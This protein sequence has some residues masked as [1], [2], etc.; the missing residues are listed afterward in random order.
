MRKLCLTL[1]ACILFVGVYA[2]VGVTQKLLPIDDS[3][4][5][6]VLDNRMTYYIK[7]NSKPEKSA[8]FFIVHNVGAINESDNQD[9]LAH[10]LEHM[11]FNGTQNFPKKELVDYM[12][13][14]GATFGPNLNAFTG[15]E[16][17][18]YLMTDIPLKREAV[19]DSALLILNDWS[20]YISLV[21][22]E[23]DKERG[24]ILEELRTGLGADRRVF[25]KM[26][27]YLFN[28]TKYKDRLVI[29]TEEGLK[30]FKQEDIV[31]FY[32]DWYHP[33]NQAVVIIGD[34][35][36]AEV[37]TKV[38]KLFSQIPA[39]P[40]QPEKEKIVIPD[41]NED[42][43]AVITD[44]EQAYTQVQ[45]TI[46]L[47][48]VDM[49]KKNSYS[50]GMETIVRDI[51]SSVLNE[52]LYDISTSANPPFLGAYFYIASL[53]STTDAV[54]GSLATKEGEAG[55]GIKSFTAEVEK[56]KKHGITMSEFDRAI[57]K[58]TT[59]REKAVKGKSDRK[60][61]DLGMSAA[62]NFLTNSSLMSPEQSADFLKEV[63]SAIDKDKVNT[64]IAKMIPSKHVSIVVVA[65]E[66]EEAIPSIEE[67]KSAYYAGLELDLPAPIEEVVSM[68]LISGDIAA[69]TITQESKDKMGNTV[70]TLSNGA[71]VVLTPTDHHQDQVILYGKR[72]GGTSHLEVDDI[73][74]NDIL[75]NIVST[76]GLG[77]FDNRELTKVLTGKRANASLNIGGNYITMSGS[78][79]AKM[80]D[81]ETMMQL[82]H[83][84]FTAPR[85]DKEAFDNTITTYKATLLN[86]DKD[87]SNIFRDSIT[88]LIKGKYP[89]M[90]SAD[91][92]KA[93]LD[94][95]ILEDVDRIYRTQFDGVGGARI[96]IIGK[97]DIDSIRPMVERYIASLPRGAEHKFI[98]ENPDYLKGS[99]DLILRQPME[100]PKTTVGVAYSGDV[101][102]WSL[103]NEIAANYL[104]A[105]LSHKYMD[106][107]REEKGASYGVNVY[108]DFPP[109]K[110]EQ[111]RLSMVFET[112]EEVAAEM[113]DII[114]QQVEVIASGTIDMDDFGM[115]RESLSKDFDIA[116]KS[117]SNWLNWIDIY[118]EYGIIVPSI[119]ME[120]LEEITPKDISNLA[121]KMVREDVC[122]R[123]IMYPATE[124]K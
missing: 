47:G 68:S 7:E 106:I 51:V 6:G 39:Q 49:K 75:S 52:R 124:A 116:L 36:A 10:F 21:P 99:K 28:G 66:K 108:T 41:Y 79:S 30:N 32:N 102:K 90:V 114:V 8:S 69:G 115:I 110:D 62:T 9:G 89:K 46:P 14:I 98:D 80:S 11:A 92:L 77:D 1:A 18:V 38:K 60:S 84:R 78:S 86:Y 93:N 117:N 56:L 55:V 73:Y 70:W 120:L 16:Q 103:E 74:S 54:L 113:A 48:E 107:I 25:N 58:L 20:H 13:S 87:P 5:I 19:I 57:L 31:S 2:Q 71:E 91:S 97:F 83:L 81:I 111:F 63:L 123:M 50:A 17:T 27:P 29:G 4:K 104:S 15:Q 34:F 40:N 85:F 67:I 61:S 121:K 22:E 3:F 65:P 59:A 23:V 100:T 44:P 105:L 95:I 42:S 122:R 43:F 94:N 118:Q 33:G 26:A 37:E 64:L 72:F 109:G 12:Q 24:V 82:L 88:T 76:S 96:N 53:V 45:F 35:D 119:Y 112:N 101:V